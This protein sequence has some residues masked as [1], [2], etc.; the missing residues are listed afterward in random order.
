MIKITP[1]KK[2]RGQFALTGDYY[3]A[4]HLAALAGWSPEPIHI[5]GCI[6]SSP[7]L[8]F[9]KSLSVLGWDIEWKD[10]L[11]IKGR[12][13]PNW[14]ETKTEIKP[15]DTTQACILGGILSCLQNGQLIS[16]PV[17]PPGLY[18]WWK[19]TSV[20]TSPHGLSAESHSQVDQSSPLNTVIES[21]PPSPENANLQ[22]ILSANQPA[23]KAGFPHLYEIAPLD[24][25]SPF[26]LQTKKEHWQKIFFFY[27][28]LNETGSLSLEGEQLGGVGPELALQL[29]G[30]SIEWERPGTKVLSELEKRM[31]RLQKN[32]TRE[33]EKV[34]WSLPLQFNYKEVILPANR[35]QLALYTLA[36]TF[37]SGS[38]LTLENIL[39][40][41]Q[42]ISFLNALKKMG[43]DIEINP[44][45][46]GL[47]S[48]GSV[49]IRTSSLLGRR[50]AWDVLGI[51]QEESLLLLCASALAAGESIFRDLEFLR[52]Y[53]QDILRHMVFQLKAFGI[54]VGIVEDGLVI[55]GQKEIQSASFNALENWA[56]AW[57][58]T[59][60]LVLQTQEG[61][62]EQPPQ[63]FDQAFNKWL[64]LIQPLGTH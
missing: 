43:A 59:G 50:F 46:D 53:P 64:E 14:Q 33:T 15:V 45:K 61:N 56:L 16:W 37:R 39:I 6:P 2:I 23:E 20:N 28:S 30:H 4:L 26:N 27:A 51:L 25:N 55:R 40:H 11:L 10:G 7:L 9:V 5:R 35:M 42:S 47:V 49:R 34:K 41:P 12:N 32:Q 31:A 21:I 3:L 19:L 29:L 36:A 58:G 8:S 54:E 17:I 13:K 18:R 44:K 60:L 62:L 57:A 24:L 48:R 38:D 22:E 52:S 1:Q 63:D